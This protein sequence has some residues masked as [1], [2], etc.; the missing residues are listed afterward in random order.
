VT[1]K[2]SALYHDVVS[3]ALDLEWLHE[4]TELQNNYIYYLLAP[5]FKARDS[6]SRALLA[7]PAASFLGASARSPSTPWVP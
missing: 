2:T 4:A 6:V 3:V 1:H 7:P 5:W